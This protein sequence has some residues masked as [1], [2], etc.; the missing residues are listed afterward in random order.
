MSESD[1]VAGEVRDDVAV[2]RAEQLGKTYAEG[3]M[4]TNGAALVLCRIA[5]EMRLMNT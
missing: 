4:R 1:T 2:I 3:R 5:L